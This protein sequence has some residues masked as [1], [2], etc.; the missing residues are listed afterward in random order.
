M[1]INIRRARRSDL[2]ELIKL[3]KISNQEISWWNPLTTSEFLRLLNRGLVYVAEQEEIIAY[4]NGDIK[5]KELIL[6][7]LYV[8]KEFRKK[9]IARKLIE[10][11]LVDFKK[12]FKRVRLDCPERMKDFY[13]QFG[14]KTTALI[15][16][17]EL[18]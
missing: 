17:K 9:D 11:F 8:K 2:K 6:D 3:D 15:M 18:R 14:F 4:L 1:K 16:Q 7:N 5:E 13:E 10:K 12:R